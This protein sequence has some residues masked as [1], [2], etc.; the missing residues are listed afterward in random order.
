MFFKKKLKAGDLADELVRFSEHY[1]NTAF[2]KVENTL[3]LS[4]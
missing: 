2:G 4:D 1:C 3:Q